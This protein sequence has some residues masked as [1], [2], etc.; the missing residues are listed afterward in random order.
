MTSDQ[1]LEILGQVVAQTRAFPHEVDTMRQA[2][3]VLRE[4]LSSA[5]EDPVDT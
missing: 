5:Q 3:A 1:A 2:L 4:A